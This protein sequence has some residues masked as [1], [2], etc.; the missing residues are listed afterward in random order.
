VQYIVDNTYI[1]QYI[2]D[3]DCVV[4]CIA[5]IACTVQYF[6]DIACT[7]QYIVDI[8]YTVQYFEDNDCVVQCIADI[9]CS[10]QYIEDIAH[11]IIICFLLWSAA[12]KATN[13]NHMSIQK[14]KIRVPVS[15][16][17]ML[18]YMINV[19]YCTYS[20]SAVKKIESRVGMH[21]QIL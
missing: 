20:G 15:Q 14:H 5:D 11:R 16:Q 7:V 18:Q 12:Q 17:A 6:A 4:H 13:S 8:A 9:P 2:E 10:R 21:G 1:V 3:N 19:L